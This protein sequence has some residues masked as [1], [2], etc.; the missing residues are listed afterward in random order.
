MN[1][2]FLGLGLMGLPMTLNLLKAG[3]QVTVW[4]RNRDKLAPALA[5]GAYAAATPHEAAEAS[6]VICLCVMDTQ[7]VERVVFGITR[8]EQAVAVVKAMGAGKASKVLVDHSSIEPKATRE[9]AARLLHENGMHWVDAPVSG[10]VPGAE[11]GTLAIM[12][13]GEASAVDQVRPALAAY[14]RQV[15]HMGT[16][17]AGQITKLI[18]Q[19]LV[20]SAVATVAEATRLAQK[21]GIDAAR[22]P[23][24]LAGG[25]ADSKPLQIWAKRIVEGYDKPLGALS[26]FAKDIDTALDLSRQVQSP[27]LMG[28]IAQQIL[29]TVIAQGHGEDDPAVIADLYLPP[30]NNPA[31]AA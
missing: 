20:V 14:A 11:A 15:T 23:E 7:A 1:I 12:A 21:A 6:E 8:Q 17:G 29:R 19:I 28:A 18:N 26:T 30:K 27:L 16:S 10:G 22:L 5:A 3:H 31:N 25:F 13:G 24:A 4:N 9:F 2:S